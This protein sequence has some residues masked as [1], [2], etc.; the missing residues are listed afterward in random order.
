MILFLYGT[1]LDPTVLARMSGER[2][3]ARRL[4]PARLAGWR[5]VFL[6]GTLCPT[7]VE[8]AAAA[9]EGAVLRAGPAALAR[10]SDYEGSAYAL[11]PLTV[12]TARGPVRAQAWIAPPWRA[13]ADR[14][15][16]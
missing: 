13:E 11:T 14:D 5:R 9:V 6:R 10:L 2:A 15:W 7:L 1:L 3:L 16:P 4:R 12:A 8:D